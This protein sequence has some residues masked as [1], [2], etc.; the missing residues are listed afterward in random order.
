[1]NVAEYIA[2]F[3]IS[4][5]V[6]YVFGFQGSAV[7]KIV[8]AMTETGK[9]KFIQNFNEQASSFAADA[10]GRLRNDIGVAVATSGPGA[11]NLIGG[12]ANAYFDSV[13]TL[14]ITGQDYL[15]NVQ[16]RKNARQ[17]G[18]QDLDIVSMVKPVCK[19]AVMI[20]DE[21][22]IKYELEKAYYYAVSGRKG[23]V[24]IDIPIDIQFKEIKID[25]L[26]SFVSTEKKHQEENEEKESA[27]EVLSLIKKSKRPVLLVGG[28]VRLAGA[29]EHFINF[30]EKTKIPVVATL[31]GLD[32]Y[33]KTVGFAGLYGNSS[34]NLAVLNAD[35]LIVAG[36][37]LGQRQVGK[38]LENYTKAKIVHIDIDDN[39]LKRIF[40]DEVAICSDLKEFMERLDNSDV[41]LPDFSE[42]YEKVQLWKKKYVD[43]VLVN[44]DGVEPVALVRAVL[45]YLPKNSVVTA[46][47]GQNQMW[48]AQGFTAKEGVRFLSSSGYGSMGYSLPAAIGASF[49][50]QGPVLAFTGDGGLQMNLQELNTLSLLR[51]NV[52][53]VIFNNNTL[54]MMRE[55]QKRYYNEHYIG[56]NIK[57]F[58]CPNVEM[59][60]KT[61]NLQYIKVE[62]NDEFDVLKK[63][64]ND[65]EPYLI[66]VK[67]QLNSNLL[68][69]Y[70]DEALKNG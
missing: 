11:V 26:K 59:L 44:K 27:E 53:C 57:E 45:A 13:P 40:N 55:V 17:N 66:D 49:I 60:A 70:D 38:K 25:T 18:F 7:L 51:P 16:G 39:E 52:K 12:I 37:R 24:V 33:D 56:A 30:A 47:V 41:C 9:I 62:N 67:I 8:D 14:F 22:D 42:W 1:M 32:V 6:R 64:F 50:S 28:G 54:G 58:T 48:V 23:S 4:K 61:F 65:K 34:A 35:L 3:L 43:T 36:A 63:V 69:R 5:G 29:E 21:N 20:Q 68:N 2:D 31:N 15:A 19:Y 10:Q 46:D